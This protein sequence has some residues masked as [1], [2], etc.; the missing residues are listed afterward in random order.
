MSVEIL[1][2]ILLTFENKLLVTVKGQGDEYS[3]IVETDDPKEILWGMY[4]H[5]MYGGIENLENVKV[6]RIKKVN[7]DVDIEKEEIDLKEIGLKVYPTRF[8][9]DKLH[10]ELENPITVV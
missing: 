2:T 5:N 10:I 4:H 3:R 7:Y 8:E 6:E 1:E 9:G